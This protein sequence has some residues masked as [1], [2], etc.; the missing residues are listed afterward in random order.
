VTPVK[1]CS[2]AFDCRPKATPKR[3]RGHGGTDDDIVGW[4]HDDALDR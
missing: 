4:S 3:L 1:R 2:R